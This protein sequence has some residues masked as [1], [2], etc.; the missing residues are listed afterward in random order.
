MSGSTTTTTTTITAPINGGVESLGAEQIAWTGGS[1]SKPR[2]RPAST[3]AYR[4]NDYKSKRKCEEDCCEGIGEKFVLKTPDEIIKDA[5]AVLFVDWI[6]QLRMYMEDTGQDGVFY[7]QDEDEKEVYFLTEF[8]AFD[9]DETTKAVNKIKDE[10]CSYDTSN[11]K[12]SGIAIR[13]SLSTTMLQRIKGLV[14]VN[15]S[16]PETLAAVVAAHQILDST[17]CRNLV[18]EL[19]KMKLRD[20]PAEN[21]DEFR[22]KVLEKGRRIEGC[23]QPPPDLPAL[24]VQ[25]FRGT[26]CVDFN[27]EV[28]AWYKKANRRKITDWREMIADLTLTYKTM[29]NNGEWPA[30][31]NR[32]EDVTKTIQ[33]LFSKFENKLDSKIESKIDNKLHQTDSR[34]RSNGGNHQQTETRT[35]HHCGKA[36]H[37]KPNCPELRPAAKTNNSG[38]ASSSTT[39]TPSSL[40]GKKRYEP[41]GDNDS[42]T[43][44]LGSDTWK[45]CAKCKRWNKG[46][47]AHLTDEHR[48]KNKDGATSASAITSASGRL[49]V[50]SGNGILKQSTMGFLAQVGR[51]INKE[52]ISWCSSCNRFVHTLENHNH[53]M[54]HCHSRGILLLERAATKLSTLRLKEEAGQ[55]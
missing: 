42:H 14:P 51:P 32:K 52:N 47:S 31:T 1:R 48:S 13:A 35:C 39:T 5:E 34:K 45:W 50:S 22:L 40:P 8:G 16:G 24:I 37:I 54:E 36:G 12:T 2:T 7:L 21:V 25:C 55:S 30:A 41:P 44:K 19:R 10:N 49:A 6:D 3:K 46:D 23:L 9:V 29:L 26:Q 15:A 18:E 53:S 27:M 33:G 20:F 11:L 28:A 17:G 38:G 43:K 4:P